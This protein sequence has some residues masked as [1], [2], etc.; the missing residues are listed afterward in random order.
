VTAIV[1]GSALL[2]AMS[3]TAAANPPTATPCFRFININTSQWQDANVARPD[4]GARTPALY[5]DSQGVIHLEGA[6]VAKVPQNPLPAP[7]L[8]GWTYWAPGSPQ[9]GSC[10][11][12]LTYAPA[13]NVYTIVH[14][15]SGT[16]ANLTIDSKGE[17]WL[18]PAGN[19]TDSGFVSL[20]GISYLDYPRW[21]YCGGSDCGPISLYY[22]WRSQQGWTHTGQWGEGQP[23]WA[24][25]S[26]GTVHLSGGVEPN[27]SPTDFIGWVPPSVAPANPVFTIVHTLNGGYADV[28]IETD[29]HIFLMEPHSPTIDTGFIS[30][31]SI[32]YPGPQ[33]K[34]TS[35]QSITPSAGWS[36]NTSYGSAPLGSWTTD[37]GNI[38]HLRGAVNQIPGGGYPP[39]S[40]TVIGTLDP[41]ATP[42]KNVYTIVH[43][44]S[45]TYADLGILNNGQIVL[46]PAQGMLTLTV[47]ASTNT[48]F[49]SLDGI[50]FDKRY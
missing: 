39:A 30:L 41:S 43:T 16:H 50:T 33:S 48:G 3:G 36:A 21:T 28:A 26:D 23:S 49:V 37:N 24:Q 5:E 45:G 7:S 27:G 22:D 18:I 38:V 14:T 47:R 42:T 13:S 25:D 2:L 12:Q 17:I 1:S 19:N 46:Y 20:E 10:A 32:T 29:G 40:G 35:L 8:L 15:A 4:L 9:N 6:L 11:N 34:F 31:D 44:L